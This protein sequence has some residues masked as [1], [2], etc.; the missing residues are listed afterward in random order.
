MM[1]VSVG[2][3]VAPI[4]YS[5]NHQRPVY[6]IYFCSED[7]RRKLAEI[8]PALTFTPKDDEVLTTPSA[9][10]LV[11][12]YQCARD[13]V[14]RRMA[15]WQIAGPEVVVDYTGGTKNMSA[16]LTLATVDLGCRYSYVGGA[17]RTKGGLGVV[18]DGR[19]QMFYPSNP[20]EVLGVERL[21][22]VALFFNRA[23]Y[24]PAQEGL[25]QVAERA[26]GP[27]QPVYR[28][29][30]KVVE[31]FGCWDRFDHEGARRALDQGL[32][33][34]RES[35]GLLEDSPTRAFIEQALA[36]QARLAEIRPSRPTHYR[37][38]LEEKYEDAVA[39]LY[40]AIEKLGKLTLKQTHGLDN[41][42]LAPE[43]VPE[44]LREDYRARYGSA[45]KGCLQV[46]LRATYDLLAALGDPLG[47]RVVDGW[48]EIGPLLDQRNQSILGHGTQPVSKEVY[49][50]LRAATLDLLEMAPDDLPAF[51]HWG[52]AP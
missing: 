46:P 3:T 4:L 41:S 17:E 13:G 10:D 24:G 22:E 2:S 32:G 28:H 52:E 44:P 16:A 51:P 48:Q 36:V 5:L 25:A 40:A 26:P 47:R 39:R 35:V 33:K 19:E 45:D 6:V 9:E 18:I 38:D 12:A 29:L 14:R 15:S 21:R 20:W 43:A 1:V 30:A 27:W 42:R 11:P 37:A 34:L 31:G 7:S 23:R 49:K 8:R 50:R